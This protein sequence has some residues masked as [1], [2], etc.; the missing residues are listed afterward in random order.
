[1]IEDITP[2]QVEKAKKAPHSRCEL[3]YWFVPLLLLLPLVWCTS[4]LRQARSLPATSGGPSGGL[5]DLRCS[6]GST[7]LSSN[8]AIPENC[9]GLLAN[10][11]KK[12]TENTKKQTPIKIKEY[13]NCMILLLFALS[14]TY[15]IFSRFCE[16]QISALFCAASLRDIF[17]TFSLMNVGCIINIVPKPTVI[18]CYLSF[19]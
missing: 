1:M 18:S 8:A 16:F 17:C 12:T 7:I 13:A 6:T 4:P 19:I 9:P 14:K 2:Q 11:Q 15:L 3:C 10:T 5:Q